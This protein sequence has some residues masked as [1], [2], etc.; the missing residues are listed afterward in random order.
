MKNNTA[1]FVSVAFASF[2]PETLANWAL[3]MIHCHS[4]TVKVLKLLLTLNEL[5]NQ[6]A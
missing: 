3:L 4:A 2:M 6:N 1:G 5:V